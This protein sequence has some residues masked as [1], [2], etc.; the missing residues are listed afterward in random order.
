MRTLPSALQ[1]ALDSGATTL[2]R[3]WK[4]VRADG[5]AL[6][7]TDHDRA[8][9]FDGLTYQPEAGFTPSAIE[10]GTGLAADSHEVSGAL[11]SVRITEP[12]IAK[13]CYDRAE[14]TLYLVDWSDPAVRVV[15]SR[16]LIGEIR[17]GNLT[18]EAEVTGLSD[19][20]SQPVGCAFQHSC[21]C[22]LGDGKCGIDLQLPQYA[23]T[24]TVATVD[25]GAR[26]TVA[27]L[28]GFSNGWFTGG[29]LSWTTGANAGLEGQ[30][31]MH[32]LAGSDV[33]VELWLSPVFDVAAGDQF[34]ISAGCD[35]TAATCRA[36]FGNLLN[37]RGFPHMPGDDVA[38]SYANSGGAHDGGSLFRS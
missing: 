20:L 25:G 15:L 23:G 6:G 27:G 4:V 37:F 13:G 26:F 24:A 29:L 2:A 31:K 11:S 14:V 22:R 18:F 34:T 28:A 1:A 32:V 30:V 36:K 19:L 17:Q 21:P 38:A 3:C 10:A 5:Q 33:I 12:D 7:F 9:S 35:K 8:L 16:G